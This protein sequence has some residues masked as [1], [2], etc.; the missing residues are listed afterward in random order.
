MA[1]NIELTTQPSLICHKC[2]IGNMDAVSQDGEPEYTENFQCSNCGHTAVIHSFVIITSQL[3][4]A[5]SG[6]GLSLYLLVQEL[7]KLLAA[8]QL[9]TMFNMASSI[10]L[11]LLAVVM[12]FGFIY[13]F[14]RAYK[15]VRMR[16]LYTRQLSIIVQK[17]SST[18]PN[19]FS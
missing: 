15:A 16:K 13:T 1:K 7:Y 9:N 14:Y 18:P 10:L 11:M 3:L 17:T 8:F 4:T 19:K 6:G 5:I 12:L 2:G